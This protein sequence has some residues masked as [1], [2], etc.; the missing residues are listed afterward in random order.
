MQ[1]AKYGTIGIKGGKLFTTASPCELCAKK[2]YQLGIKEIY[3]IDTYPGISMQHI[4]DCGDKKPDLILFQGAIGRAYVSL[5]NPM[6]PLKDEIKAITGI[7][8][9]QAEIENKKKEQIND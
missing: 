6:L 2:A 1:L 3:Y 5:Y 8:A 4:L 7:N 9:K